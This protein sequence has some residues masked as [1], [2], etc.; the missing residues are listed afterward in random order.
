MNTIENL[1]DAWIKDL[2]L[3]E[4]EYKNY[5]KEDIS[6]VKLNFL[7]LNNLNFIEKFKE[8]TFFFKQK[9]ILTRDEILTILKNNNVHNNLTYN[10]LSILKYNITVDPINL[11][12][13]LKKQPN[14]LESIKNIDSIYFQPTISLFH[15]LNSLIIIFL[16][17]NYHCF[18][19]KIY[20]KQNKCKIKT[21]TSKNI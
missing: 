9:N 10:L 7:Y 17:K 8:E 20:L 16:P 19:K 1:D 21:K 5:Y 11:K 3:T 2:E 14:Y 15:D 18:T 12:S 4:K 6:F 13:F